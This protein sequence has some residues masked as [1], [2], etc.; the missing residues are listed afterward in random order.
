M[1]IAFP[2]HPGVTDGVAHGGLLSADPYTDYGMFDP[3]LG[4]GGAGGSG[5]PVYWW[6]DFARAEHP[7]KYTDGKGGTT[8]YRDFDFNFLDSGDDFS[9]KS[10]EIEI[11]F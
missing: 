9:E 11:E 10:N 6:I 2:I 3:G 4:G 5:R 1:E 7:R 8:A